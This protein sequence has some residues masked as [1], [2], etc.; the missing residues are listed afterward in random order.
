MTM[1]KQQLE[2]ELNIILPNSF[3]NY[4]YET[5][6]NI[7]QYLQQLTPIEKK[8]YTIAIYHL[9]SSFHLLRS[10]GFVEWTKTK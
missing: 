5:Q 10:N 2:T 8:A 7:I 3:D 4:S 9:G 1:N 6:Q